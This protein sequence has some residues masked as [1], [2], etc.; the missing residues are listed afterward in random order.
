VALQTGYDEEALD[1]LN[2]QCSNLGYF[3][4]PSEL[5]YLGTP[6]KLEY[7]V[8]PIHRL[9]PEILMEIFRIV[10]DINPSPFRVTLVCHRWYRVVEEMRLLQLPLELGAWTDPE[11][12]QHAVDEMAMRLLNIT[13]HTD[14][15]FE[16]G[17]SI[18]EPYSALTLAA[19]NASHW[20][21]LTVHSLPRGGQLRHLAFQR[22][23]LGI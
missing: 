13:V 21:S 17:G 11:I 14:Q 16:F 4:T 7:F 19:E 12:V 8:P 6:T 15:D 2:E 23:F 5:E 10:F 20:R 1:V 18:G 22:V 9:P 3:G